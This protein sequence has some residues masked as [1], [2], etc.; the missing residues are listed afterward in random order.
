M[1][2][3]FMTFIRQY[4]SRLYIQGSHIHFDNSS[5]TNITWIKQIQNTI[6]HYFLLFLSIVSFTGNLQSGHIY[7]LI[8]WEKTC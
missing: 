4:Q 3:E 1:N 5:N 6:E 2:Y 7:R 8:L